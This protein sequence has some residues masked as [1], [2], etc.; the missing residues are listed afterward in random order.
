MDSAL[1]FEPTEGALVV[2][3]GQGNDGTLGDMWRYDLL[4]GSWNEITTW[5]HVPQ[6]LA[7]FSFTQ[8]EWP[9]GT[10]GLNSDDVLM[11]GEV[12]GSAGVGYLWGGMDREQELSATLYVLDLRTGEFRAYS[13][14][15]NGPPGMVEAALWSD[16]SSG[17]L[18]LFGGYDGTVYHNWLWAL[19]LKRMQWQLVEPDCL[20]GSCPYIS[21]SPMVITNDSNGVQMV[22]PGESASTEFTTY[23]EPYFIR[24]PDGWQGGSEREPWNTGG[25]CDGDGVTD[26]Y[27]GAR[28]SLSGAWWQE[29][30]TFECD[31]NTNSLVCDQPPEGTPLVFD[32]R[33]SN[34]VDFEVRDDVLFLL[35]MRK[36]TSVD[37]T[38]PNR[39]FVL[40]HLHLDAQARDMAEWGERLVVAAGASLYVVDTSN[41]A[42]LSIER[43]IPTCGI[44]V[45]VDIVEDTAFFATLAGMGRIDLGN[46]DATGPDLFAVFF[47]QGPGNWT[48]VEV[49]VELCS[50]F[51]SMAE[52][53]LDPHG[54]CGP[55]S[56]KHKSKGGLHP[57]GSCPLLQR[58]LDA[59]EGLAF[60]SLFHDL[61]AV[62]LTQG[63]LEVAAVVNLYDRASAVRKEGGFAYVNTMGSSTLLVNLSR[64]DPS[65]VGEHEVWDWVEGVVFENGRAYRLRGDVIEVAVVR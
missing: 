1:F 36:L 24:T 43:E 64:E 39:P 37:A 33:V 28:C 32:R 51:S 16:P 8:G 26:D 5:G 38:I 54:F 29:P 52:R 47:P 9:R 55:P 56:A 2:W 50:L 7:D 4:A 46:G 57:H 14:A 10:N 11:D 21:K 53:M 61:I 15:G 22:L 23:R 41:P 42:M 60:T 31:S 17:K 6:D 12:F 44:P 58:V 34:A 49:P 18:Y 27:A 63:S 30:G 59:K 3:G 48:L 40:N 13:P 45:A 19:H 25:D 35:K 20:I 62:D 65:A